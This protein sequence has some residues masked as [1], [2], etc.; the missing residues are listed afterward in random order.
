MTSEIKK[1]RVI[2]ILDGF[3]ELLSDKEEGDS[4][5]KSEAMLETIAEL[6]THDSKIILTT[7]KTAVLEG[8]DFY[9]WMEAHFN[10]FDVIRYSLLE[11]QVGDWLDYFRIDSL[12]SNNLDPET[13]S[14]PVLLSNLKYLPNEKFL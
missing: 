13:I 8:D 12:R 4:F 10:D 5:D 9:N 1:N 7:R 3:D 2:T 14:N 11:P 6:L